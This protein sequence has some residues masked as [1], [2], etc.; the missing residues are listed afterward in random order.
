MSHTVLV[1]CAHP[2]DVELACAGTVKKLTDEGHRV[3]FIECTHAELSTRG[4]PQLR[5]QEAEVAAQLLGVV[6]KENLDMPDGALENTLEYAMRIVGAIRHWQPTLMLIPS[7]FERHPDHEA[8]HALSRRAA[9]LSGLARIETSRGGTPQQPWR[10]QRMLCYQ[11]QYDFPRLPDIYVD[12]TSVFDVKMA[13]IRAFASQFHV[14][15]T[16]TSDEPE[17]FISRPGFL[18]EIE[19]RARYYGGR[20]GTTYAEAFLAVE[21]LAV[22]SLSALLPND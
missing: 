2:D 6:D 1:V 18:E 12:V 4:T 11:Q 3:V 19:A 9:F 5:A 21:P 14:P 17:T 8:V 13:S 10:P 7:P 20:I 22:A 15:G 16:Y